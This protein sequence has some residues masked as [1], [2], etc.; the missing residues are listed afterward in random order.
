[1]IN[2]QAIR[3]LASVKVQGKA[4]SIE[5]KENGEYLLVTTLHNGQTY[6][7]KEKLDDKTK[8]IISFED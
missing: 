7:Y 5:V 4:I 1:M 3:E 2:I 6:C 8:L